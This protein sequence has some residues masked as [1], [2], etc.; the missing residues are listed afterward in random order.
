MSGDVKSE[1]LFRMNFE[2]FVRSA[3]G[4]TMTMRLPMTIYDDSKNVMIMSGTS[5]RGIDINDSLAARRLTC[6]GNIND[7]DSVAARC[8]ICVSESDDMRKTPKCQ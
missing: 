4:A 2:C 7:I 5:T 8:L 6:S 1:F 3:D